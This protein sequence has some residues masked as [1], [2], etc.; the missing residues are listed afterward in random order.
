MYSAYKK[1]MNW[2]YHY[3][4]KSKAQSKVWE[5]P[6]WEVIAKNINRDGYGLCVVGQPRHDQEK[7]L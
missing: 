6:T 7:L 4:L 3:N 2:I 1:I 5:N